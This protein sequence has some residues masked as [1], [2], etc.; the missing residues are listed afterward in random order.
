VVNRAALAA[1]ND[2]LVVSLYLRPYVRKP[3]A[4]ALTIR[5][6]LFMYFPSLLFAHII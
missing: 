6:N 5:G 2:H 3:T 4:A 1:L